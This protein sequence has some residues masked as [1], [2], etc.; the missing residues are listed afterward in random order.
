M[1]AFALRRA[2]AAAVVLLLLVLTVFA[3]QHT[4]KADPVR[5]KLG[6]GASEETIAAERE[7][8]GWDD[9]LPVQFV[10]YV[11]GVATG[12]FGESVRTSRPVYDDLHAFLP[13]SI[14]LIVAIV[15]VAMVLGVGLGLF[16]ARPG[17]RAGVVRVTMLLLSSIPGFLLTLLGILYLYRRF[18]LLPAS[19]RSSYADAPTGPTGFLTLDGLLAGRLDVTVDALHHL[20]LP[21][22]AAAI[23]PAAAIARVLR[24]S[25][26]AT[27]A[28]DQVRT[29]RAKGLT[30]RQVLLRHG[31]R[32]SA[33][34]ALS[35]IGLIVASLFAGTLIVEQIMAWPG[36]GAY[37]LRSISSTDF[38]AIAGVTLVLGTIY[39]LLN[40]VVEI[41]QTAVDPRL[42]EL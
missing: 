24:S 22:V 28:S 38:P 20:I 14:E 21:A 18:G 5:A 7:R 31:L 17:A 27:L 19:G 26:V 32:N 12:D 9:P 40:T 10:H 35:L 3:L 8:L 30:E 6:A 25:L 4:S 42:R 39:V 23:V 41:V 34:P 2:G 29:A 13:A 33:G 1:V 37:M 16:T 11:G 36:L 15:L